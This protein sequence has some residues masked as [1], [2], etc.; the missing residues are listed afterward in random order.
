MKLLSGSRVV[1]GWCKSLKCKRAPGCAPT[2]VSHREQVIWGEFRWFQPRWGELGG[3]WGGCVCMC[4]GFCQVLPQICVF[5]GWPCLQ[6]WGNPPSQGWVPHCNPTSTTTIV[7]K[8]RL[9]GV[10]VAPNLPVKFFKLCRSNWKLNI[11]LKAVCL[12]ERLRAAPW[13]CS[14][15]LYSPASHLQQV[16]SVLCQE[17]IWL[18]KS[19]LGRNLFE[20]ILSAGKYLQRPWKGADFSSWENRNICPDICGRDGVGTGH[21]S[22]PQPP[23]SVSPHGLAAGL[24]GVVGEAGAELCVLAR[25]GSYDCWRL[26]PSTTHMEGDP[27]HCE[28]WRRS[29][30][31]WVIREEWGCCTHGIFQLCP[32]LVC[33][34][35]SSNTSEEEF[36]TF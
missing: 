11:F 16:L 29:G 8:T 2:F 35:W 32:S 30:T 19:N 1:C 10:V 20:P 14:S 17:M 34:T 7:G 25:K 26:Q 13:S 3:A 9:G 28:S 23:Y 6:R 15:W 12:W 24:A 4:L 18:M 5:L 33:R 22:T 36:K 27:P 21:S 31:R